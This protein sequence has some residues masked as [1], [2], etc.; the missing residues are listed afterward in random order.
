MPFVPGGVGH[1]GAEP[2]GELAHQ[3]V[4]QSVLHGTKDDDGPGELQIDL[5]DRLV[6]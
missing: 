3:V 5:L 6:G 4:V 2:V 1:A